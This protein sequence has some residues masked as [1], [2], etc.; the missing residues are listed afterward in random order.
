V[1]FYDMSRLNVEIRDSIYRDLVKQVALDGRSLSDVIR[2]VILVWLEK[3][4]IEKQKIDQ[5]KEDD[6]DR[7]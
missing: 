6:H 2:E 3:R 7:N 5:I 4:I 1:Y